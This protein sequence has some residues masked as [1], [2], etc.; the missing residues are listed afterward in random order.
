MIIP[1]IDSDIPLPAKAAEALPDLTPAEELAMRART[2]KLLSDLTGIPIVPTEEAKEEATVL[3]KEMLK[4]PKMRP[5][6][7]KYPNETMAYLAGMVAQ[8]NC[9]LVNEL[10]D[11][12][13]YIINKLVYE[14]E[15][16][17]STR[18]RISALTK[19]GEI[20]GI[21]AF[22]RR[23]EVTHKILPIEEV[24]KELLSVLDNIEYRVI[25]SDDEEI[26]PADDENSEDAA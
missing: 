2:M 8:T 19:L 17:S 6:F 4:D 21:D 16:S 25:G 20:D 9:M 15:H 1:N 24:E 10:T 12:K 13:L 26:I 18:D 7:S 23:S 22:K 5:D 3:A 11:Y 14:V